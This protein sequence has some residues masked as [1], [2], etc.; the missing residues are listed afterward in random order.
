MSGCRLS[1]LMLRSVLPSCMDVACYVP[2][3]L[4]IRSAN[5]T[6]VLISS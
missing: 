5:T 2:A 1:L 4:M 3:L 6:I